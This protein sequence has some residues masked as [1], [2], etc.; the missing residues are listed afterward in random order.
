MNIA[1]VCEFVLGNST[2]LFIF[3]RVLVGMFLRWLTRPLIAFPFAVFIIYGTHWGSLAYAMDPSH[4]LVT[5][6]TQYGGPEGAAWNSSQ[7]W[8]N[9]TM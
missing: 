5:G 6:L 8:H 3:S 2:L 1:G 7:G 9:V 4:N